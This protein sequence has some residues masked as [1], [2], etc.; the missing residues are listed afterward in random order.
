MQTAGAA[1]AASQSVVTM[2]STTFRTEGVRGLYRGVSAPL[3][4]VTPLFAVSF[5]GYDMGQRM[6]RYVM[7]RSSNLDLSLTDKTIAGGLSAFPCTVLM[8]PSERIKVLLQTN[9]GKYNGMVDCA[10]AVYVQ[11][12]IKSVFK[13]T[14][15]TLYRDVPGSMAW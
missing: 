5:W 14:L 8:A 12:G 3:T 9:P 10:K 4:A 2:F 7:N 13:G 6:V 15:L 11:G 1:E